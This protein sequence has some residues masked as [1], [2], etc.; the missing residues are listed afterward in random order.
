MSP[1]CRYRSDYAGL[2]IERIT[3]GMSICLPVVL[4]VRRGIRCSINL[5]CHYCEQESYIVTLSQPCLKPELSSQALPRESTKPCLV[6]CTHARMIC[7]KQ[8]GWWSGKDTPALSTPSSS[9]VQPNGN[10][11]CIT[12][13]TVR[14]HR[15]EAATVPDYWIVHLNVKRE[16]KIEMGRS[17]NFMLF[18][19][20][21][22]SKYLKEQ[23]QIV[24]DVEQREHQCKYK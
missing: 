5:S 17:I 7:P 11:S 3:S 8:P 23:S 15:A 18:D 22:V 12:A 14:H 24:L 19:T 1:E 20:S 4:F 10:P 9:R 16:G 6:V 2:T 21:F 13:K